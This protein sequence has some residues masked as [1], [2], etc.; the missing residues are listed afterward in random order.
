MKDK[1]LKAQMEYAKAF[2]L[3]KKKVNKE[4]NRVYND[5]LAKQKAISSPRYIKAMKQFNIAEENAGVIHAA[6]KAFEQ[7]KDMLQAVN[8]NMRKEM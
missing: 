4:T 5:D 6:L 7:R 2:S 3:Y 8:A 1:E